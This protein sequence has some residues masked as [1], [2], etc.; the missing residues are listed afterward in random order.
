MP[1]EEKS[2][3]R[4]DHPQYR[5]KQAAYYRLWKA[6]KLIEDPDALKSKLRESRDKWKAANKEK[7]RKSTL[8]SHKRG[9]DDPSKRSQYMLG[10]IKN[11]AKKNGMEFNITVD[12]LVIPELCPVFF[13]PI[14]IDDARGKSCHD[15]PNS[16]SVDR[17]DSTKGYV[18]DNIRVISNR[19]NIL[20]RNSTTEELSAIILYMKKHFEHPFEVGE[21]YTDD[22][23][24]KKKSKI[25][26]EILKSSRVRNL[27]FDLGEDDICVP[28]ICPVFGTPIVNEPPCGLRGVQRPNSPSV[29]RVDNTRGYVKNNIRIIS[30][31]A[32]LLK[33]A[34]SLV[35]LEAIHGY[36]LRE[37]A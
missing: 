34:A 27:D 18:K 7:E 22:E 32:N 25:F 17:L 35:E 4:K 28:K 24:Y 36:M 26:S 14:I 21:C 11:R 13:V 3:G 20:K 10:R 6:R 29:D 16:P 9:Y 8:E 31:R 19:A 23:L 2:R 30:N 15:R 12:D 1:V 37:G 5:E 33:G